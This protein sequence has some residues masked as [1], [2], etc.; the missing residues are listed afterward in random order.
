MSVEV[1]ILAL[2]AGAANYAFR[3]GPMFLR[4]FR[5]PPEGLPG[6]FLAAT[7]PA[8]IA[9]LAAA[10][11]WP[12]LTADPGRAVPLAAGCAAVLGLWAWRRSVVVATLGG[13]V[14]HGLVLWAIA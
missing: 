7:G 14:V 8:A 11:L 12:M 6:R 3:V 4:A 10:S 2:L 9:T 5:G 1:L 13:P